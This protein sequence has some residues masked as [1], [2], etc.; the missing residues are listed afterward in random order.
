[1]PTARRT[2]TSVAEGPPVTPHGHDPYEAVSALQKAIRRGDVE[3][4]AYFAWQLEAGG[5]GAWLWARLR[6]IDSADC[7][8]DPQLPATIEALHGRYLDFARKRKGDALLVVL[9]A[10]MTD[11]HAHEQIQASEPVI[12]LA[13]SEKSRL[14]CW[15]A[16]AMDGGAVP[17][18]EV[19]DHALDR[20][21]RR[22]KA[23]AAP[24]GG[25][26][27]ACMNEVA[28][29]CLRGRPL[30]RGDPVAVLARRS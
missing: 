17:R 25:V 12:L 28:G 1:M 26:G 8:V 6:V 7:A 14:A 22:G 20:H 19:P 10:A 13:Q 21:T 16:V 9:H 5:L 30:L 3:G 11:D 24:W 29:A 4:A 27:W 18:R 2:S 15:M 23:I